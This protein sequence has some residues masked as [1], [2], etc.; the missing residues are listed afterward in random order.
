MTIMDATPNRYW[1]RAKRYGWG[2]GLPLTWEGWTVTIVWLALFVAGAI[3]TVQVN[4]WLY[5]TFLL[6]ML[7]AIIAVCFAKGEPPRWRWGQ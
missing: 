3:L 4:W 1:F 5:V 6:V 2:W 7:A